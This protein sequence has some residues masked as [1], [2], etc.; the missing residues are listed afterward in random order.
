MR[1]IAERAGVDRSTVS[2][3]LKNDPRLKAATRKKI[4]RLAA[5]MGYRQNPT[6]AHLMSL[7]RAGQKRHFQSTIAVINF[8]KRTVG[9]DIILAGA[10]ERAKALGY[11]VEDFDAYEV[12][13]HRLEQILISRGI[14]GIIISSRTG[15]NVLPKEYE[16]IWKNFSC[17]V[18]GMRPEN[19][20]LHFVADDNFITMITAMEKLHTLGFRRI[21]LA[22]HQGINQESEYRF[23]GGY[24]AASQSF[25]GL[26]SIPVLLIEEGSTSKAAFLAWHQE[27]KPEVIVCIQREPLVWLTGAG[28]RVPQDVSLVSLAID[29]VG[30]GWAGMR[31]DR[32]KRGEMAVE[33]IVAQI[34]YNHTG[35]TSYQKAT[36]NESSW[37]FGETLQIPLKNNPAL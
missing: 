34:N 4:Q 12:P 2:L 6:V 5:Q 17:C 18:V 1:Q 30:K 13:P 32:F 26:V 23:M 24:L 27:Q 11:E 25:S 20:P 10:Q 29:A 35:A 36:L 9:S 8:G 15:K 7:L 16:P 33:D 21:G 3:A 19:P 31:Q 22:M 28:Y 14:R 37:E